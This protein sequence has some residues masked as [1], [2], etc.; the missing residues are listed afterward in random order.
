MSMSIAQILSKWE[1]TYLII[2]CS[3]LFSQTQAA[4]LNWTAGTTGDFTDSIPWGGTA[5]APGDT[6]AS[7]GTGSVINYATTISLAALN[8]NLVSGATV[9]NHNSGDLTLTT[10]GFGG[11]GGSLN[12]TYNLN[13]GTLTM[14]AFN[15]GSG[16]NAN[17]NLAGGT[18]NYNGLALAIG[19][20]G[21]A[22][23]AINVSSGTFHHTGA[24]QLRLGS[25][26][27]STGTI[28]MTGGVFNTNSTQIR[29]GAAT[30][31]GTVNLSGNAIF[32]A[33]APS[34]VRTTYLG[35]NN[36]LGTLTLSDTSQFN[37]T[38]HVL[39][40]GQFGSGAGTLTMN[41]GTL[42]AERIVVG[43]D[44]TTSTVNG[45]INLNG[46]TLVTGN[47][48]K[49]TSSLT[50]SSTALTLQANGGTIQATTLAAGPGHS[51]NAD[52]FNGGNG[53]LRVEL[54]AGGLTFDTNGNAVGIST[55]LLGA[56]GLT[57]IGTSTLTLSGTN[58]YT[59]NTSINAGTLALGATG[60]INDS[61]VIHIANGA[62][63]DT[64]AITNY[65]L[66]S[67][68][69]LRGSGTLVTDASG[70]T[71]GANS[72]LSPGN[73][74]GTLNTGSQTW[75]NG[76]T[77]LWEINELT[78]NGGS[79]GTNPGWD[80]TNIAGTLNIAATSGGGGFTILIDSLNTLSGWDNSTDQ[81]WTIARVDTD[82]GINFD[83]LS[84]FNLDSS[85]FSDENLLNG[86]TFSLTLGGINSRDLNLVFTAAVPEPSTYALLGAG[87]L[88]LGLA[89]RKPKRQ[90]L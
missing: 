65:A 2:I 56:G 79:E 18:T 77:Y 61:E 70:L 1:K 32:N 59:G 63:F 50:P 38:G 51:G 29:I 53:N 83:L 14:G 39:S 87:L 45:V 42:R 88:L 6:V 76:G 71:I 74:P 64:S 46:G 60:S 78:G 34:G 25:V 8:L 68:Q 58:L 48:K 35:N 3:L 44:N 13:G 52:F 23:G 57:K 27:G 43:G 28:N 54:L 85:G 7:D 16:T 5:P 31:T 72:T 55:P 11:T 33:N 30:S 17:F 4:T 20:A 67:G 15:W 81:F 89:G 22:N 62:T 36:G 73:S 84:D 24:G 47:I 26:N 12:P 10:L 9:F 41:G 40:V 21:G 86:G 49:G 19:I 82:F 66:A 37:A 75:N 80:L 69:T 90:S